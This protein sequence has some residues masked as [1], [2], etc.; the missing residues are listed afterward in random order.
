LELRLLTRQPLP[1]SATAQPIEGYSV[2]KI[3][4]DPDPAALRQKLAAR[5][6]AMFA[7]GL[8][9]EV[10]GL[11]HSGCTGE[12]KP[13]ESLGYKQ[14]LLHL[15][16]ALTRE[17]AIESTLIET[18]QYAKRQRTW[19]RRDSEIHWLKG[20]GDETKEREQAKAVVVAHV[21]LAR[22]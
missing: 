13:F 7:H 18:R 21:N 11:L 3:G 9:E 8:I 15:R 20:F 2:C 17:Q 5:T 22:R 6:Q 4:L 19:F 1:P 16:G 12:E 14:A 10:E